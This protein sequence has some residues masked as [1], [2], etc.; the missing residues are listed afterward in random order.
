MNLIC[1]KKGTNKIFSPIDEYKGLISTKK[2][3]LSLITE[4]DE[5]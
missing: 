3:N 2:K 1:N 5:F 4:E